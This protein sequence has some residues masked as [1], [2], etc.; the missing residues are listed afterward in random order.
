LTGVVAIA[1]GLRHS[2]ALQAD[3]TVLAWGEN[4]FGQLGDGSQAT[5][6]F[7]VYVA[8]AAD[9]AGIAAGVFAEHSLAVRTDGTVLAWG[10]NGSG[11]LCLG[12]GT[13]GGV[14]TTATPIPNF[15]LGPRPRPQ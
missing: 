4:S 2:L 11:Q 5:R 6:Y 9:V 3:G 1:A 8:G 12:T 13:A 7:P 14:R 10:Q 15:N